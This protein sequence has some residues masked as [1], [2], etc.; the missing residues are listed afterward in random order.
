MSDFPTKDMY[1]R[2][3]YISEFR[4][5]N[6]IRELIYEKSIKKKVPNMKRD[7]QQAI[8]MN[9]DN[10]YLQERFY[11]DTPHDWIDCAD[12]QGTN[13]YCDAVAK[14]QLAMRM[15]EYSPHGIHFIDSGNY[16]YLSKLWTDKIKEPFVLV[17]F[18][19]HTDM[20]SSMFDELLS[21]GSW[22][23]AVMNHNPY[24]KKVF[25][26]GVSE[27]LK[28][29]I[30]P[31][32]QDMVICFDED[33]LKKPERWSIYEEHFLEYPIYI[34]IDKDV[35][36]QETVTTNW[37]QGT[38]SLDELEYFLDYLQTL[39]NVVGVDICGESAE[40]A[41]I[42]LEEEKIKQNDHVNKELLHLLEHK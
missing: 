8:I 27:K 18:D 7:L 32:Y 21:C 33:H 28:E 5:K 9:M 12:L 37:D 13:C 14:E 34:S 4:T 3:L 22:V 10:I 26:I 15:K 20:Q 31:I 2:N 29:Q 1:T 38:M 42:L 23:Q 24:L 17:V 35:L 25:L 11:E 16:H 30:D 41:N 19:Y 39:H 36:N 6:C 40:T